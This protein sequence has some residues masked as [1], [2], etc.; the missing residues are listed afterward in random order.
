MHAIAKPLEI[1][2]R[3]LGCHDGALVCTPLTGRATAE[4]KAELGAILPKSPDLIEWRVD[5]FEAIADMDQVLAAAA[6]LR[7]LAGSRPIV[8]TRRAVHEGGEAIDL[9]EDRVVE[10]YAALCA[11]GDIDAIDYEL[12]QPE[13]HRQRLR[14]VS[15]AHGVSLIVS[16]HDFK[17]TPSLE[18]MLGILVRAAQ[19]DAD[20]AKLAVMPQAPADVLRLL[21]AT[22]QASERL[23]IPLITMSMGSLGA[24]TRVCGWQYGSSV[25]FAVGRSVSAPGQIPI[26]RLR[27][28]MAALR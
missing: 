16:F 13:H 18:D 27:E 7:R 20:V 14:A 21:G 25:S 3:L 4:L 2:G 6:E 10:L 15:Q 28:A 23:A 19:Q 22:L 8:F 17:G 9:D 12:S 1:R 26:D 11:S 5:Y 24:M